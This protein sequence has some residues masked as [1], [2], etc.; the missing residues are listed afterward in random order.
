M[1]PSK[2]DIAA[3]IAF[4]P[5]ADEGRAFLFLEV[6]HVNPWGVLIIDLTDLCLEGCG[7]H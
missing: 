4:A 3:F 6:R 2:E 7:Y 1:L 5:D